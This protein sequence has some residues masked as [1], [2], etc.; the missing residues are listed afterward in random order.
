MCAG[1]DNLRDGM[2]PDV[3]R[4]ILRYYPRQAL[5]SPL[6]DEQ[7]VWDYDVDNAVLRALIAD[8]ETLDPGLRNGTRGRYDISE[9]LILLDDLRLQVCYLGPYAA[10]DFGVERRRNE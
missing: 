9:E 5:V 2:A 3:E 1:T 7:I 6:D 4:T 10:L 8:L